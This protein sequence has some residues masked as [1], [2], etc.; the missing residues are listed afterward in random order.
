MTKAEEFL[1]RSL[2]G[3]IPH[4]EARRRHYRRHALFGF[5]G[6]I[7]VGLGSLCL[8]IFGGF[9]GQGALLFSGLICLIVLTPLFIVIAKAAQSR[10]KAFFVREVTP[11]CSSGLYQSFRTD[12]TKDFD[13]LQEQVA[14]GMDR[15][16]VPKAASYFEGRYGNVAFWTFVYCFR[17]KAKKGP[18]EMVGRLFEFSLNYPVSGDILIKN[19]QNPRLFAKVGPPLVV[20]TDNTQFEENHATSAVDEEKAREY[21]SPSLLSSL[22]TLENDYK[23]HLAAYFH[24]KNLTLYLDDCGVPFVLSV[25]RPITIE[26]LQSYGAEIILGSRLI[27]ALGLR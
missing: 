14:G 8:I 10:Y 15:K 6:E 9:Y 20:K 21:L 16:F 26:F 25:F 12:T 7:L 1:E 22:L 23:G 5:A 27:K 13:V 4:L 19:K 17:A 24:E 11:L 2:Q 18:K 3:V